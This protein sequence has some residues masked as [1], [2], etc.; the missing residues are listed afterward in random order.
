MPNVDLDVHEAAPGPSPGGEDGAASAPRSSR[1]AL[2]TAC[3]LVA[4][5][6][7]ALYLASMA[8]G[9]VWQDNGL[10]QV[11]SALG[12][13]RGPLGLALSHPLYYLVAG[14]FQQLPIGGPAF[15]TNLVS[16]VCCA[17]AVANAFLFVRLLSGAAIAGVVAA[18][19]IAVAHT[20]W[21]HAALPETYALVALLLTTELLC[22]RAVLVH[23]SERW[24]PLLFFVNGLGVSNHLLAI[25]ALPVYGILLVVLL[26]RRRIGMG[27]VLFS[28]MTWLAGC[29]PYL[30][31]ILG[32]LERG[33]PAAE[34]L[35]SAL[36]GNYYAA[37][38]LNTHV[39]LGLLKKSALYL[40]LNFP[41]PAVV[42][43]VVGLWELRRIQPRSLALSLAGLLIVHLVWVSR[44]DI[45]DQYTFF[46]PTV[47]LL[48][49]LVGLGAGRFL[50]SRGISWRVAGVLAA[51][52]PAAVY[53]VLPTLAKQGG[54]AIGVGRE[55]PY[56]DAYTYFLQ[57]WKSGYTGAERFALEA[58]DTL[59]EGAVLI[60]DSTSVRP[61][62]YLQIT[63]RWKPS[64]VV[65]P[66]LPP[67]ACDE[68]PHAP[69]LSAELRQGRVYVVTPK[70]PYCPEWLV[71]GYDFEPSG[72]L[73]RVSG[74]RKKPE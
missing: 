42:L 23:D 4:L 27:V 22:L 14:A 53:V 50:A 20:F 31:L 18:V 40:G 34:V 73:Y 64:V 66:P 35:G 30:I 28:A 8:P 17:L 45:A 48:G 67:A 72:P 29:I 26:V 46:I 57:P 54:L 19:S 33:V 11:R 9:P 39:T 69:E 56:R 32:E 36:F 61:I 59:P 70:P 52:L 47:I 5:A 6:A 10:V 37:N 49:L 51:G 12:D 24:L 43:A 62:Q 65:W 68:P 71:E 3:G 58:R 55:L 1:T 74:P 2:W 60:A 13:L 16:V 41:T 25:L 44:Y 15:R 38:V 7:F 21:Q 63:G